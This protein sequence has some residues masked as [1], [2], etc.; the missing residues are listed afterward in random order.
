MSE[1]DKEKNSRWPVILMIFRLIAELFAVA[2]KAVAAG[3]DVTEED[4]DAAFM[5]ADVAED[6]WRK[7]LPKPDKTDG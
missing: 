4:V 7:M 3:R 5:R 1:P 2:Q 6:R